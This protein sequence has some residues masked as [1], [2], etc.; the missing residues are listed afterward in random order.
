M[1]I[2]HIITSLKLGGAEKFV[3]DIVEIQRKKGYCVDVLLLCDKKNYFYIKNAVIGVN[4]LNAKY[5]NIHSIARIIKEGNYNI[6]HSHLEDS[7]VWTAFASFLDRGMYFKRLF[8]REKV[9]KRV[10]L[11]TEYNLEKR[12]EKS[13]L[14]SFMGKIIYGRYKKIICTSNIIQKNLQKY[15]YIEKKGKDYLTVIEK[16][17]DLKKFSQAEPL[18]RESL[19]FLDE[20]RVLVMVSKLEQSKNHETLL[21]AMGLLP[22]KY[23]MLLVGDGSKKESLIQLGKELKV[24]NRVIFLGNRD[25][26]GNIL[27][28]SDIAIQSS[29]FEEFNLGVV[30]AMASGI[31]VIVSDIAE[32]RNTVKESGM[33]FKNEDPRDL[34]KKIL[35]L[36]RDNE[37]KKRLISRGKEI[38][39]KYCLNSVVESYDALYKELLNV[40]F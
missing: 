6:V 19:G 27:K 16:G 32:L 34:A 23:K 12:N 14:G 37:L 35:E 36:D 13:I 10:Y 9:V 7:K 21:K 2:L 3:T 30:E 15:K 5:K 25:D 24:S 26:I 31:P 11:T 39:M 29:H 20:D 33:T 28:T 1:K 18:N 4:D 22:K 40:D 8:K 38:S 17:I